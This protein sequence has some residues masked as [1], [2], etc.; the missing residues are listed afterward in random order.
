MHK[1]FK[2]YLEGWLQAIFENEPS[3]QHVYA[4]KVFGENLVHYDDVDDVIEKV[5][6]LFL[7]NYQWE[8]DNGQASNSRD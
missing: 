7:N 1:L 6:E 8:G 2:A 5:W 3:L 4:E